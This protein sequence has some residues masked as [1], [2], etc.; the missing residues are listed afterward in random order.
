MP[1]LFAAVGGIG[2]TRMLR[3]WSWTRTLGGATSLCSVGGVAPPKTKQMSGT[4]ELR[5]SG[6][7]LRVIAPTLRQ[8]FR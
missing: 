4:Q 3:G 5:T 6:R 1:F 7:P 2:T 8:P